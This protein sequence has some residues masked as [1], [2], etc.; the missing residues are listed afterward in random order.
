MGTGLAEFLATTGVSNFDLWGFWNLW[1]WLDLARRGPPYGAGPTFYGAY[2]P[3]P[4]GLI[5]LRG[6]ENPVQ[7][8][9]LAVRA[10]ALP[11]RASISVD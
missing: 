8:R 5:A 7:C 4:S 9:L 11:F 3:Y 6:G 2:A 1:P 10:K